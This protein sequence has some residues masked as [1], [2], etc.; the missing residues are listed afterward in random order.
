MPEGCNTVSWYYQ[1]RDGLQCLV[2][3]QRGFARELHDDEEEVNGCGLW[4]LLDP[5]IDLIDARAKLERLYEHILNED[6]S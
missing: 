5:S 1:D 4:V 6:K 2:I 3:N